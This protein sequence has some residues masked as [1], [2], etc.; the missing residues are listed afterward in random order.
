[1]DMDGRSELRGAREII[2]EETK[3]AKLLE[4]TNKH[5]PLSEIQQSQLEKHRQVIDRELAIVKKL[6]AE[7]PGDEL[8]YRTLAA[9]LEAA[10]HIFIAV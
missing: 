5:W 9:Q 2:Q 8:Q 4:N 7:I 6:E 10:D 1:M 3:R